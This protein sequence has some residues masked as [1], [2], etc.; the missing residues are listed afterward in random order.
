MPISGNTLECL[1]HFKETYLSEKSAKKATRRVYELRNNLS[2]LIGIHH[3]IGYDWFFRFRIPTCGLNLIKIRVF[4]DLIGYK[5]S[6]LEA[7]EKPIRDLARHLSLSALTFEEV[8]ACTG[9][10]RSTIFDWLNGSK[11]PEKRIGAI[12]ELLESNQSRFVEASNRW[13][14]TVGQFGVIVS[15][16]TPVAKPMAPTMVRPAEMKSGAQGQQEHEKV[17]LCLATLIASA[18]PLANL[19]ASDQFSAIERDKLR[20]LCTSGRNSMLFNLSNSLGQLCTEQARNL[21]RERKG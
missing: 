5:V 2:D 21:V 1:Q 17:L 12:S 11:C 8:I 7:L 4:L 20:S 14:K 6:E 9:I 3:E 10:T 19:V 13:L 18:E 16:P 15:S